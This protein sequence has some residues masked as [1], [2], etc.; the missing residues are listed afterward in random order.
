MPC[1]KMFCCQSVSITVND[2][3]LPPAFL[4]LSLCPHFSG[5]GPKSN[6]PTLLHPASFAGNCLPIHI[7]VPHTC[8]RYPPYLPVQSSGTKY[9]ATVLHGGARGMHSSRGVTS[10]R[11]RDSVRGT[12][13]PIF[14]LFAREVGIKVPRLRF[15]AQMQ[16]RRLHKLKVVQGHKAEVYCVIFDRTGRLLVTGADD[17][18]VKIWSV[19]SGLCLHA[20]RAHRGP[21]TDLAISHDNKATMRP[22][23][24]RAMPRLVSHTTLIFVTNTLG[25]R[26]VLNRLRYPAL[27][28][29][30]CDAT[31]VSLGSRR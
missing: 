24:P 20:L 16:T 31:C 5:P 2:S 21:I 15:E 4:T 9:A 12:M 7:T 3:V 13:N 1:W 8:L 14:G 11:G 10:L 29:A 22:L 25:S 17:F 30:E 18:M 26:F 19:Q 27:G 28:V 6:P 23:L